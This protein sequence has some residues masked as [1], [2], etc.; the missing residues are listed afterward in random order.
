[1]RVNVFRNGDAFG[2]VAA[3]KSH[4]LFRKSLDFAPRGDFLHILLI[5]KKC[6]RDKKVAAAEN[7]TQVDDDL[8][9]LV[10][11]SGEPLG[12]KCQRDSQ[13]PSTTRT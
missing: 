4:K 7:E 5:S 3:R 6:V 11:R 12:G 8:T 9:G 10:C 13:P 1:M 2:E